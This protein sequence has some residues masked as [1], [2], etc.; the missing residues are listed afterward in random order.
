MTF[1]YN[2]LKGRIKEVCVTNEEFALRMMLS[3]ATISSKLNNKSQWTQS[4]IFKAV[5]VLDIKAK[6]MFTE[7]PFL[8]LSTTPKSK[9]VI[10][11]NR[12]CGGLKITSAK[13]SVKLRDFPIRKI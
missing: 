11:W 10:S 3:P 2:R 5:N 13:P 7:I 9:S 12:S 4:E 1:S 8:K 6:D